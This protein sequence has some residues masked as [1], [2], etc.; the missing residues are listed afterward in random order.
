[1]AAR[2][3]PTLRAPENYS[4]QE[5]DRFRRELELHLRDIA[6]L[7]DSVNAGTETSSSLLSKRENFLLPPL[8][9]VIYRG[10]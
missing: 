3:F 1:M 4:K 6:A 9:M 8:G 5:E 7:L 2:V 10:L